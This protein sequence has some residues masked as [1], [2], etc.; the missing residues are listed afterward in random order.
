[1]YLSSAGR[2]GWPAAQRPR[3][4]RREFIVAADNL[5]CLTLRLTRSF[6]NPV[7][8]GIRVPHWS[9]LDVTVRC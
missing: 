8:S 3:L 2:H 9:I 1:M 5:L 4:P 7:P 6:P